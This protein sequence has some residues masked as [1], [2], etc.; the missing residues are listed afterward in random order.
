MKNIFSD[1]IHT[2]KY[3]H[4]KSSKFNNEESIDSHTLRS[5]EEGRIVVTCQG[6][7]ITATKGDL[8][9]IPFGRKAEIEIYAEPICYGTVIRMVY[10]PDVDV[11][12]YPPQAIKMSDELKNFF[13]DIP[14]LNPYEEN[15]NSNILWK[16]YRFLDLFQK[17][18][19][20]YTDKQSLKLQNALQY[21]KNNDNY[22]IKDLADY[23]EISERRLRATFNKIL[24]TTP[25]QMKHRIQAVK[26][27]VLL[28]TTDLSVE[29]IANKVGYFSTNQLRNVMKKRYRTL[30]KELRKT[31]QY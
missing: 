17:E 24:D 25:I 5:I 13:N 10:M 29:E 21:M 16:V 7:T 1:T 26:A 15:V 18:I 20:K 11:L 28:K 12:G 27:D 8:L 23:C 4:N 31:K 6:K 14:I 22:S 2:Y 9:Y 30:P 19:T 3:C